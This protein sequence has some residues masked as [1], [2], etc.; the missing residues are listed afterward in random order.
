LLTL[1]SRRLDLHENA[2]TKQ[3]TATFELPGLNK[4]DVSID[5]HNNRLTVSGETK[6]SKDSEENGYVVKERRRGKFSRTLPLPAGT[7]VSIYGCHDTKE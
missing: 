4:E 2:E 5:I 3:I 7:K 1:D 6:F